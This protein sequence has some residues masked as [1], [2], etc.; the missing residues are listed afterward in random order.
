MDVKAFLPGSLVDV[1]P[2]KE[3]DYLEGKTYILK[4]LKWIK[5]E[6]I[7]SYQERRS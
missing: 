5:L 3:T 4:L 6:T 7:L 2:T 1:R